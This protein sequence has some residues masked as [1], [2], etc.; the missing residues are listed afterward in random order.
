ME[1]VVLGLL[2]L[3]G[4]AFTLIKTHLSITRGYHIGCPIGMTLYYSDKVLMSALNALSKLSLEPMVKEIMS[5]FFSDVDLDKVKLRLDSTLLAYGSPKAMVFGHTIY[6]RSPS[7][8]RCNEADMGLLMHELVHVRQFENDGEAKFA[9]KYG[10][11]VLYYRDYES[12]PYEQEAIAFTKKHKKAMYDRVKAHPYCI[13]YLD[14]EQRR[15]T[16]SDDWDWLVWG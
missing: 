4:K 10:A 2:G 13:R 8:D 14:E 1:V 16:S 7:F 11:G 15:L 9:C 6:W 5:E 12:I 3:L